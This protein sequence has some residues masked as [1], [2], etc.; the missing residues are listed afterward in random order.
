MTAAQM[1]WAYNRGLAWEHPNN[2]GSLGDQ[3]ITSKH[4]YQWN[5]PHLDR[6]GNVVAGKWE[7]VD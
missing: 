3:M 5:P 1:N 6:D 2:D 7:A 4:I